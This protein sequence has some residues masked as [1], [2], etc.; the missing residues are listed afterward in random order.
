MPRGVE[1]A[2]KQIMSAS[3]MGIGKI[4]SS[5]ISPSKN[6]Q[7]EWGRDGAKQVRV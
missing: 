5:S 1:G 2:P 3:V 7:T 4:W 6:W